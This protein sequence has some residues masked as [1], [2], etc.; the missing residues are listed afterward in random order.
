MTACSVEPDVDS[1]VE[2]AGKVTE[3]SGGGDLVITG[4]DG[5]G[6]GGGISS[7]VGTMESCSVG[8]MEVRS[9]WLM[10]SLRES[11]GSRVDVVDVAAVIAMDGLGEVG[12]TVGRM[13]TGSTTVGVVV[14]AMDGLGEVGDTVGIMDSGSSST[15]VGG[16]VGAASNSK[17]FMAEA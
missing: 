12:D 7:V 13:D 11:V 3:V 16:V 15:G 14:G 8:A 2:S 17:H 10:V 1:V 4:L 5:T 6:E 9:C